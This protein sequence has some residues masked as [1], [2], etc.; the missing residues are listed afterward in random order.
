MQSIPQSEVRSHLDSFDGIFLF[1]N[2]RNP[3]IMVQ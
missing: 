1:T 2:E 3:K